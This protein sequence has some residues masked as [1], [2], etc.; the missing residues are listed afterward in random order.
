MFRG[1]WL[2]LAWIFLLA[3]GGWAVACAAS[4]NPA[5]WL[6]IQDAGAHL[7][8]WADLAEPESEAEAACADS[9]GPDVGFE[10]APFRPFP[11]TRPH[12]FLL[13]A[14]GRLVDRR[15]CTLVGVV[16]FLI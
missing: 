15:E 12:G 6:P 13:T 3:A 1:R 10:P 4:A 5:G 14:R 9:H 7:S 8:V 11:A 16:E 2:P